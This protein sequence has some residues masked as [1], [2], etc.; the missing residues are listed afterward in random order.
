MLY[1]VMKLYHLYIQRWGVNDSNT[2][3]LLRFWQM[4]WTPAAFCYSYSEN[5]CIVW[6]DQTSFLKI[7]CQKRSFYYLM[8]TFALVSSKVIF[9]FLQ[10]YLHQGGV[11][12]WGCYLFSKHDEGKYFVFFLPL[13]FN[14][15]LHLWTCLMLLC[16]LPVLA[17]SDLSWT[18]AAQSSHPKNKL[19]A[20]LVHR[21]PVLSHVTGDSAT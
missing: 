20:Q 1:L 13:N 19:N 11:I 17:R 16:S 10:T 2:I 8:V 9:W 14:A 3:F 7:S 18:W 12:F 6:A 4:C 21:L 15:Y 5:S